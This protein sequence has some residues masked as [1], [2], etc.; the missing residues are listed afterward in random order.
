MP[1]KWILIL[2]AALLAF[3]GSTAQAAKK[4]SPTPTPP[5]VALENTTDEPPQ[6]IQD[7][8]DIAYQEWVEHGGK[9][10]KNP[11]KFTEWRGKGI[12]FGWCGGYVTWCMM[13]A[14]IPMETLEKTEEKPVEGVVHVKEASVGKLL[15][16][17][18]RMGRSTDIPKKGFL[19]VYGAVSYNLTIHI[20]IV[21]DV[22][23]LGNGKYRLTT[24]EGNMG[25]KIRMF[26]HDYDR[27]AED[28]T[29]N[30]TPPPDEYQ[31]E[32]ESEAFSY[33]VVKDDH[34]K[35][36]W[37]NCFLMPWIPGDLLE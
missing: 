4:A 14:G 19:A 11:N 13:E 3:S 18:Q 10:L 37:I 32:E 2:A 7:Y 29:K 5:P 12:K 26:V 20:G 31:T 9:R 1:R 21:Y 15:R 22:E 8:L 30:L 27:F 34:K 16:G 36:Y 23:D 35:S 6:Q 24:L 17:Y 25:S 28:R 33:K